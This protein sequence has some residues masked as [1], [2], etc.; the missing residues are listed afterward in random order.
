MPNFPRIKYCLLALNLGLGLGFAGNIEDAVAMEKSSAESITATAAAADAVTAAA[1]AASFITIARYPNK[2]M[3]D[4]RYAYH[5]ELIERALKATTHEYGAYEIAPYPVE[6]PNLR[7]TSEVSSGD[8]INIMWAPAIVDLDVSA[9]KTI[10]IPIM[11]GL[12]GLRI[13]MIR[14]AEQDRFDEIK[15]LEDFRSVIIGQEHG[16]IDSQI[17]NH[18]KL[19]VEGFIGF[20]SLI[21]S[22]ALRRVDLV[23]LGAN[24]ILSV[25]ENI[26]E[27]HSDLT[28]EK[29]L[30]IYYPLP[31]F[32]YISQRAPVLAE[33]LERGMKIMKSSGEFDDLFFKHFGTI[34]DA[35][36]LKNR[37]VI[38]LENNHL[39]KNIKIEKN[40]LW[41]GE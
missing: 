35:L 6:I 11:K 36:D 9:L 38:M 3:N 24:E 41:F 21:R 25:L 22:L 5:F 33:R 14:V 23:P 19:E 16:W 15:N 28:F 29:N 8:R 1:V 2:D 20:E 7:V 10:P 13:A 12:S 39:N 17:Y 37:R 30:I 26:K 32:F 31:V 40:Y 34:V 4:A 18:N 27:E